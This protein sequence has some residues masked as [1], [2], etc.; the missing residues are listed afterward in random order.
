MTD[1]ERLIQENCLVAAKDLGITIVSPF[2]LHDANGNA[3]L[4]IAHFPGFGSAKGTLICHA[5]DWMVKE[6]IARQQ[7]YYCSGLHPDSYSSYDRALWIETL[8]DWAWRGSEEL[9]PTWN[10][11]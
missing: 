6:P 4:F 3:H 11:G 7:G 5:D 9:R 8:D 10:R 1:N 2:T